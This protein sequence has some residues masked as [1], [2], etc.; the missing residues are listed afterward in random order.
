MKTAKIH[1][2]TN[3]P[4]ALE[5]LKRKKRWDCRLQE[6]QLSLPKKVATINLKIKS[7]ECSTMVAKPLSVLEIRVQIWAMEKIII[8]SQLLVWPCVIRKWVFLLMKI[9]FTPI[10]QSVIGVSEIQTGMD[11]RHWNLNKNSWAS[12]FRHLLYSFI[13]TQI[14]FGHSTSL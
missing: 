2:P 5:A 14:K 3:R 10:M 9:V 11:F 8:L 7:V 13:Y 1:A 12:G 4:K 6:V